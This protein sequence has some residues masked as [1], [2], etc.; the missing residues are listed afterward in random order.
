MKKFTD[1]I[2]HIMNHPPAYEECAD[3]LRP[4]DIKHSFLKIYL[5]KE[6]TCN[7]LK[8]KFID[9]SKKVIKQHKIFNKNFVL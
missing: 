3:K 2:T 8:S 6:N 4:G 1:K 9:G 7:I 5:N